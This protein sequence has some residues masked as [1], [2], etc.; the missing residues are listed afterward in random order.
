[1]RWHKL[2]LA[3]TVGDTIVPTSTNCNPK[4]SKVVNQHLWNVKKA[5]DIFNCPPVYNI[6]WLS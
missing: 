4:G 3:Y 5:H 2:L 6:L 1:M